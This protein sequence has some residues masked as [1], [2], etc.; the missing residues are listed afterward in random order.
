V[1]AAR[2]LLVLVVLAT[3]A[4]GP[5]RGGQADSV[6]LAERAARLAAKLAAPGDSGP[7]LGKPLAKWLLPDNLGEI[8]GIALTP[9]GRLL[10]H[11][12]ER[13]RVTVIDPRRGAI[14]KHFAVGH[15]ELHADL[16]GITVAEGHIYM[17]TSNGMLYQ[18]HERHDTAP[19]PYSLHDTQLGKEC[20]FEGVAYDSTLDALIMAC[21]RVG[22]KGLKDHLVLYRWSLN[23]QAAQHLT[24]VTVPM[25]HV[26]RG[27]DWGNELHPTDIAVDPSTGHYV[28]VA[29]Q[30][31]A[32]IEL[33]PSGSVVRTLDLPDRHKQTEG[34]AIT[35]DGL[36]ILSDEAK[37][38]PATLT[39]YRWR[40]AP[41]S[42]VGST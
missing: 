9:D 21:K 12:D 22:T 1:T 26:T 27:R 13:A 4:C 23:S 3:A 30:D 17:I 2:A 7:D 8:S 31:H 33:T 20:E 39:L 38:G 5:G 15:D 42:T 32:I 40:S 29:A 41:A 24:M 19:V 14:L 36:L 6:V 28:I 37:T 18:F 34:I 25:E 35:P 10:A 16:E 11:N